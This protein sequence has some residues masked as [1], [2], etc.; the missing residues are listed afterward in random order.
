MTRP[1][2]SVRPA[3][4]PAKIR[5]DALT[6]DDVLLIPAHS[7]VLPREVDIRSKF[8]RNI[9]L[10]IPVV[11]AAMDT[12]RA[13]NRKENITRTPLQQEDRSWQQKLYRPR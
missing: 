12:V 10:N 9:V 1:Q 4:T 11:S 2:P 7:E 8:T 6:F 3:D 5:S 13:D